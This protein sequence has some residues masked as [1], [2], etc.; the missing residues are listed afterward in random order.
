MW[1]KVPRTRLR[2][3]QRSILLAC[4]PTQRPRT[5]AEGKSA[6]GETVEGLAAP[7]VLRMQRNSVPQ[8]RVSPLLQQRLPPS[9]FSETRQPVRKI[10][11]GLLLVVPTPQNQTHFF[12]PRITRAG[13]SL[14]PMPGSIKLTGVVVTFSRSAFMVLLTVGNGDGDGTR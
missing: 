14:S 5:A 1:A 3:E 6:C 4:L 13:S 2:L 11:T 10:L 7:T 8:A 9:R 12:G